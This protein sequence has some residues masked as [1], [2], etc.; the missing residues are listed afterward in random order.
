MDNRT[1]IT[2]SWELHEQG[3]SNSQIAIR[4]EVH[5]ESVGLWLHGVREQGGLVSFLDAYRQAHKQPRPARQVPA[6][7][8]RLVWQLREREHGCCGQK[9][10]YFLEKEHSI[11]LSVP[12]IYEILAEKYVIR[13]KWKK[14]QPRG[15]VPRASAPRQ[16][17]QMDTIDFGDVFAFTAVDIFSRE[18]DVLL[19]GELTSAQGKAFLHQCMA[20]RFTPGHVQ[21]VQTD[22]GPEF[23]GEFAQA[24]SS[25][26]QRHRLAR[27][28][29]KNEQSYIESFNRTVRKECLGWGK[30]Q[31][32]ELPALSAEVE[33]F[34]WRYHHHRPHL[35]FA[36]M[37]PPLMEPPAPPMP[38]RD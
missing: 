30:Y 12:K 21:V 18:A 37:R 3:V 26:C 8:K 23:K 24:V 25:F 14:N 10:A 16:V 15:P 2:L 17:V 28:Y 5:R 27:P 29:K 9:I 13:S 35:A 7:T 19:A 20:R 11:A 34:L 33:D 36:P 1:K 6:S 4:L 38:E 31:P 32:D 22:G